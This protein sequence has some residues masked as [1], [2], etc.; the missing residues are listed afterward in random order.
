MRDQIALKIKNQRLETISISNINAQAK[1]IT[2]LT[3]KVDQSDRVKFGVR[4]NEEL[5]DFSNSAEKDL[6]KLFGKLATLTRDE[7]G[8]DLM[9]K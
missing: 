2:E 9:K 6:D 3:S 8:I 1:A 7:F 4:L 5:R